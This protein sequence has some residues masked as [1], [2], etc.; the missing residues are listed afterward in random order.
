MNFL[1]ADAFAM[2]ACS[3]PYSKE[4]SR[5]IILCFATLLIV[6]TTSKFNTSGDMQDA[7]LELLYLPIKLN[8]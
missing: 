2:V 8:V 3:Y 5:P 4:Y 1:R 7:P 6:S